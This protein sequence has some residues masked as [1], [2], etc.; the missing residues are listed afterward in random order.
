MEADKTYVKIIT[1]ITI[2]LIIISRAPSLLIE[3][4]FWAEEG[5]VYFSYAYN[6]LWYKAILTSHLGYYAL[7]P[8]L[9]AF[10]AQLVPLEYSPL[11]TTYLAL[12][13]QIIPFIIILWSD[14][15]FW[16]TYLKKIL[17][18]LIMIFSS[19]NGEIW[20]NTINSQFHFGVIT[21][22]ILLT[23][24]DNGSALTKWAYRILLL[25]AG[26][27]GVI[28]CFFTPLFI[29][30]AYQEKDKEYI[31]QAVLLVLCS[32]L[33]FGI[34]ISFLLQNKLQHRFTNF[35]LWKSSVPFVLNNFIRPI[36]GYHILSIEYFKYLLLPL[37]ICLGWLLFDV[38]RD[39]TKLLVLGSLFLVSF[40]SH[41]SSIR[42]AGGGRY[43]FLP[44]VILLVLISSYIQINNIF[45]TL[46]SIT[47]LILVLLSL[48]IGIIEY[49][50]RMAEQINEGWPKWVQEVS[51]WEKNPDYNLKIWPQS[52]KAKWH[53]ELRKKRT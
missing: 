2:V 3:P 11:V 24:M 41:L 53:M 31:I 16:D 6:H 25:V 8:N 28:S 23:N 14:S 44:G 15:R 18:S 21:F 40:L 17:V 51:I 9:A 50:T 4:R 26:L 20:L 1:L 12:S 37:V 7:F 39:R 43:S 46:R 34:F 45:K 30:R 27:T 36:L 42:L 29:L 35:H 22:I 38:L 49:K 5:S 47:A 32:L 19:S 13:V 10:W 52:E 48:G 33:Q